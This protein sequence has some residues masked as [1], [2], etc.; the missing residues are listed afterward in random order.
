MV[1]LFKISTAAILTPFLF[2]LYS[3]AHSRAQNISPN[4]FTVI[5]SPASA[6]SGG[7]VTVAWTAPSTHSS[8]DWIG[9]FLVGQPSA[10]NTIV[11]YKYV[12][13]G[14]NGLMTFNLPNVMT[15]H[16]YEFRYLL[17]NGFTKSATSNA[18]TVS[19]AGTVTPSSSTATP[20]PPPPPAPA[21][22]PTAEA[23]SPTQSAPA[24][25]S[26][27]Y[28]V[29]AT[30]VTVA[31]GGTAVVSW[32][33]PGTHS[34]KDW[35]GLFLVS[36][37]SA[38]NTFVTW[39]YVPSGTSGVLT[40][41]VPSSTAPQL[42]EF[43]Y[44]LDNAYSMAAK[45][46]PMT[47]SSGTSSPSTSPTA[48][49]TVTAAPTNAAPSSTASVPP[50]PSTN[51]GPCPNG[52][53]LAFDGAEGFGRCSQGGRSG[54]VID[55][56]NL[57][58]SGP[59]SLREC[60]QVMSGPRTCRIMVAGTV[61]L[62]TY[63]ILV[64]NDSLTIDG[65]AY[66]LAIKDGGITVRANHTIIRHLRIRPGAAPY[67]QRGVNANGITYMSREDGTGT[68]DHI[69][70]HISVSW[71]T[72]DSIAVINGTKDVTIQDSI[73]SEGLISGPGCSNCSSKGILV[74]TGNK[75]T[76]S[77]LRVLNAHNFL[78]FPNATG[79]EIDFVNNVDYNS[80]G[81]SAQIAPYYWP[82]HINFV[83]NYW[84][85]GLSS[86]EYNG[87]F[88]LGYHVIRTIGQMPYSPQSGIYVKDNVGR[89]RRT[90]TAPET[91]I[92]W[93]DNGGVPVQ[94]VRYSHPQ[95]TTTSAL[96]AYEDVLS[97]SG[98]Q[99]RDM[100][101]TRIVADVRNGT[102]RWISDPNTVGGWPLLSSSTP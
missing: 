52:L 36:K 14:P 11:T 49:A 87:G 85:D 26:A 24:P 72:D 70:D 20:P 30:P 13:G 66:P 56:T 97:R 95:M 37:P 21:I 60:A 33:A 43:R 34:A 96:Q 22:S 86:A 6:V 32:K 71:T 101:D 64:R 40:F 51:T 5:A 25:S 42:Y 83:G 62:G 45:S 47:V 78:R 61:S 80:S 77:V 39:R 98:A 35:I 82:V 59:G 46:N 9:L 41:T 92:I 57:N 65:S 18:I 29:L 38:G 79:G 23:S 10:G 8:Q 88:N 68:H 55:V 4:G 27:V 1:K 76:L 17:N 75:E 63:D 84:K 54:V 90:G 99:P 74:G 89:S 28:A 53:P 69:A 81:S 67:T 73:I 58:D 91:D 93:S 31:P 19:Q 100:V 7:S 12:P 15:P 48:A 3:P 2:A 102:G 16:T 50:T 94:S 44:L